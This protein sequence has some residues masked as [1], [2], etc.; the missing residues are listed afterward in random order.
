MIN[1]SKEEYWNGNY[2]TSFEEFGKV[3]FIEAEYTGA[4]ILKQKKD[5]SCIYLENGKCSI[6]EKRPKSCRRFFCDSKEKQFQS[7]IEKI[8]IAKMVRN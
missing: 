6:H 2:K 8:K 5:G 4:N 7:M 1:L 3:E